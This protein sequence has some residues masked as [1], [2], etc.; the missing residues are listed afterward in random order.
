[1]R[2]RLLKGRAAK[3]EIARLAPVFNRGLGEARLGEVMGDQFRFSLDDTR[4]FFAQGFGDAPMQDLP[5]APQQ[6]FV[7]RVLH[8][9]VLE[10]VACFGRG[11]VAK[12]QLGFL[13]FRQS[14]CQ[15]GLV[16]PDH[17]VQ[18]RVREFAC[19][20]GADLCDLLHRH[21]AIEARHQRI[22]QRRGD[23]HGR[24]R[25]VKAVALGFLNQQSRLQ[26]ILGQLFHEKRHAVGLGDDLRK[27]LG[28]QLAPARHALDQRLRLGAEGR[29]SRRAGPS[30]GPRIPGGR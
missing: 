27:H 4:E 5:P 23:R 8:E 12:H 15:R 6:A 9:R 24:Q 13:Q 19:D 1:M 28:G 3:R 18:Q 20:R 22:L 14:A 7:G 17:G 25:A 16:A 30:R 21:E 11:S 29:S 10:A 2:D 26:H